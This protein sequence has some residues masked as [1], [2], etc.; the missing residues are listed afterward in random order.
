MSMDCYMGSQDKTQAAC[1]DDNR[2]L[3]QIATVLLCETAATRTRWQDIACF[4]VNLL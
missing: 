2:K 3:V 4:Q 1:T